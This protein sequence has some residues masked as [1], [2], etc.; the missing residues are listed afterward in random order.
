M[1]K[2]R[3]IDVILYHEERGK[4]ITRVI[5]S[6]IIFHET[7]FIPPFVYSVYCICTGNVNPLD[8]PLPFNYTFPFGLNTLWGWYFAWVLETIAGFLFA[9]CMTSMVSYFVCSC[10]YVESICDQFN[11]LMNMVRV[12][13]EIYYNQKNRQKNPQKNQQNGKE[14]QMQ[15]HTAIKLHVK[16]LE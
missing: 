4:K 15:L 6:Y 9:L 7:M 3:K 1:K 5:A 13:T 12:K 2:K 16:I 10:N 8:W 11:L 14:I